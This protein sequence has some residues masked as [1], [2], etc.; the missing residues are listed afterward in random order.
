[1][2]GSMVK[3]SSNTMASFLKQTHTPASSPEH[4]LASTMPDN[5]RNTYI[6]E[7]EFELGLT[8]KA[9]LTTSD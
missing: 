5:K 8:N 9:V 3:M 6:K 1:M 2:D 7:I 4:I